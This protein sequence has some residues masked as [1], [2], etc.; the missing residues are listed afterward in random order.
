MTALWWGGLLAFAAI[1][2]LTLRQHP[3]PNG[4]LI[5]AWA[6]ALPGGVTEHAL[7]FSMVTLGYVVG[8][9]LEAAFT[10]RFRI[11]SFEWRRF[12]GWFRQ[13]V[14]RRNPNLILLTVAALAGDPVWG[15]EAVAVWTGACIVVAAARNIQARVESMHGTEIRAWL[16]EP[17]IA[18]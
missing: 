18:Q 14:A 10:V 12:D 17:G 7:A 6:L 15:L 4:L 2:I 3:R 9:L 5:G 8:R 1:V 11:Q 16:D 13:V